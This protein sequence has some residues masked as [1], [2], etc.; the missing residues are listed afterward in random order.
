V[1][2]MD[3]SL[4]NTATI[5]LSNSCID[6]LPLGHNRLQ[7]GL[8]T[9]QTTTHGLYLHDLSQHDQ[10]RWDEAPQ[11]ARGYCCC[12]WTFGRM[13]ALLKAP[14]KLQT[15]RLPTDHNTLSQLNLQQP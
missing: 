14:A 7:Y 8:S 13:S 10:Q 12:C 2:A 11:A 4:Q 1:L 9:R 5:A 3:A 15:W 6:Q